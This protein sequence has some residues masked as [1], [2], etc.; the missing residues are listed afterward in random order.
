MAKLTA[1]RIVRGVHEETHQGRRLTV[2]NIEN[3]AVA[4]DGETP[5]GMTI[6]G[7]RSPETT[8][9]ARVTSRLPSTRPTGNGSRVR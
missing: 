5:D 6:G 1:S 8:R 7:C 4:V 3:V 9:R 2:D